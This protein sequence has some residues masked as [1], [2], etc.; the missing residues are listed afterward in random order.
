MMKTLA[1]STSILALA[2]SAALAGGLDRSGQSISA[3]FSAPGST[4]VSFGAVK[5]SIKGTDTAG[6]SYNVGDAYQQYGYSYTGGKANA[7]SYA[8]IIDQPYGA[9]VTYGNSPLTSTLGGTMADLS[10]H[11]ATVVGRYALSPRFSLLGGI[12]VET[13]E[14]TVNLNGTAYRGAISAAAVAKGFN[15]S[16]PSGA[17]ELSSATLG[18]A[19]LGDTTAQTAIDTTYGAGTFATLAGSLGTTATNFATNDGYKFNMKQDTSVGFLLGAAYE[20]PDIALRLAASYRFETDHS[21][22]TTESMLGLSSVPGTVDYVTPQSFNLDFQ[23]GVAK[24]TLLTAN[25]RWTDFSAVDVVPTLL[26][27]DLV[28]IDDSYRYSIGVAHRFSD[29]FAGTVSLSYEEAGNAATVSPL[30]P[31]DGLYG[32]TVVGRYSKNNVNISGGLNYTWL[33]AANA[34]VGGQTAAS[35]G[36]NSA[37]GAGLKIEIVF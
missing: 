1:L 17:A 22:A 29:Q 15:A 30:G 18:A 2:S 26:G 5:P 23:T 13:V 19:A 14:G 8:L 33:G 6:N 24:N 28:N 35:F 36:S 9:N 21:A 7:F 20:I 11:A 10:S 37:V 31:T 16:L 25:F 4:S 12:S 3:I 34:G 32:L 27:S